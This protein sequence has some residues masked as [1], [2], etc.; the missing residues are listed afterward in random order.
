MVST[1][2]GFAKDERFLAA[3]EIAEILPFTVSTIR[4]WISEGKIRSIKLGKKK[5]SRRV[6]PYSWFV[7]DMHLRDPDASSRSTDPSE[8]EIDRMIEEATAE[9]AL[10]RSASRADPGQRNSAS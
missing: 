7:E 3:A 4:A 8:A 6:V 1:M 9:I 2:K 10:L 5:A